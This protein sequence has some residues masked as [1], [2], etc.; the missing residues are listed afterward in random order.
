VAALL[1]AGAF[2]LVQGLLA[3][4]NLHVWREAYPRSVEQGGFGPC[5]FH[6][7][8][9][10]IPQAILTY[11]GFSLAGVV[12]ASAGHRLLFALPAS[13][14]VLFGL[15]HGLSWLQPIGRQWQVAC[16]DNCPEIWF[17]Y[18]W[19]GAVFDLVLVLIPA[20]VVAWT[21]RSR[22][23]PGL[24]DPSLVAAVGLAAGLMVLV[25]R[26][27]VVVT[28]P[29]EARVAWALAAFAL[30]A[31]ARRPWWPWAH[32]LWAAT[33]TGVLAELWY[34]VLPDPSS[35]IS[36]SQTLL[37]ITEALAPFLVIAILGSSWTLVAT[38]L[39]KG[40]SRPLAL[41]TALN[42]LN[43]S[44]ALLTWFAVESG[45]AQELNPFVRVLGLPFKL[46]AVGALSLLL[47][48]RRPAA[49]VWPIAALLWVLCYHVSGIV[50]NY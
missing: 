37:Y 21:V 36:L 46:V 38:A 5:F 33:T 48:R 35:P 6:C 39:R 8:V 11:A 17:G 42:F 16:F 41:V 30:A 4:Y 27:T 47:Y 49:L 28:H 15:P 43:L 12:V 1:G 2:V 10:A 23:W 7:P 44:D 14:F 29:L 9:Q 32:L 25:Y 45:G 20:V 24:V 13:L 31:G 18:P 40:I 50:V 34:L 26:T 19:V 22:R 3:A